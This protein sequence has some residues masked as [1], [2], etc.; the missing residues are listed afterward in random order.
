MTIKSKIS[1]DR[2]LNAYAVLSTK[3]CFLFFSQTPVE[4][5]TVQENDKMG[6]NCVEK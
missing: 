1:G 2:E 4:E 5:T 6:S 3:V